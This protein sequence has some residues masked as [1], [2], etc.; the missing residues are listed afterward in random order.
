MNAVDI[1]G[2]S[3]RYGKMTALR[4]L[5]LH[6]EEGEVLG[7][8][9]HNGAGKTT[10]MKLILGL[11]TPSE[12]QLR[13][14]G[15]APNDA[16]VRRRMGYLQENVM[17]YQQLTGRETL[18]HFARIKGA[19]RQQA[20]QLL[21]QVGLAHAADRRVK[22]YS[23]GMRQRLGLAQA[24]LGEPRLLLLDEPT[25]GLDPIATQDLY[26]LIDQLRQQ[27]TSVILCSHV[28][29]GVEAHINRAA[30][31]AGGQ[32]E[33]VG[34]LTSLRTDAGLPSRIRATGLKQREQVLQSFSSLN[35]NARPLG[36]D[37]IELT[38]SA[39]TKMSLLRQLLDR[40]QPGDIDILQPSLEDLY[41]FYTER[42]SRARAAE[43]K[44]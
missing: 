23:K 32:L 5:D 25:V 22:T 43:D 19:A 33:A 1:Q 37:G 7:L 14:L 4:Q 12:G 27:G 16:D 6:L 34:T 30:I 11:L 24:L 38:G 13:V 21:E 10:T 36:G 2:V 15:Q 35:G 26:L 31:L 29:P 40:D 42:A 39:A 20:D 28:L 8:F 41:R 17:F 9:G 3:L 18:H 44:A